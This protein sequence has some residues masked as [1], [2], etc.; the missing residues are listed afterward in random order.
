[1][2]DITKFLAHSFKLKGVS[3]KFVVKPILLK[4]CYEKDTISHTAPR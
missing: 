2:Q 3:V 4:T 1:M